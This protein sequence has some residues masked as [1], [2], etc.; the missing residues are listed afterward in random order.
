M[1][2]SKNTDQR[3]ATTMDTS[4][5]EI[6]LLEEQLAQ[7]KRDA[8][9]YVTEV[10]TDNTDEKVTRLSHGGYTTI[11]TDIKKVEKFVKPMFAQ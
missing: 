6:R 4:N 9:P 7:A 2:K 5:D 3:K 8:E 10:L 11:R 1:N